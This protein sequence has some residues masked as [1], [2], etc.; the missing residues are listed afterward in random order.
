[1]CHQA[2][3]SASSHLR[4]GASPVGAL[5]ITEAGTRFIPFVDPARLGIV[6]IVGFLIG[7]TIGRGPAQRPLTPPPGARSHQGKRKS[8]SLQRRGIRTASPPVK[9]TTSFET[10]LITSGPFSSPKIT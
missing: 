6:L 3:V 5:E 1:M 4:D 10:T 2:G 7:L 9:K 8:G